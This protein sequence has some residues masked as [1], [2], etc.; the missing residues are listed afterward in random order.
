MA[1]VIVN[2]QKEAHVREGLAGVV[3]GSIEFASRGHADIVKISDEVAEAVKQSGLSDGTVTVFVPGATGALTTLEFE[4]GVV[5]DVQRALDALAPA[6]GCYE[7]NVNLGDGNGHS[8]VRAGLVGPSLTVPFVDGRLTL[9][10]YQDIVFCDF[11]TRPRAR[12]LV[13]QVMGV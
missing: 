11:D 6:D 9:G 8:H 13:V 12:R 10:R 5:A 3:T 7:H 1:T 4:P 2:G